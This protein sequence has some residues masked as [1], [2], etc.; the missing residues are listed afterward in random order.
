[1]KWQ[2]ATDAAITHIWPTGTSEMWITCRFMSATIVLFNTVI[3]LF[4]ESTQSGRDG[5]QR[6]IMNK[7]TSETA[8]EEIKD[9]LR[10]LAIADKESVAAYDKALLALSGGGIALSLTF[11]SD[12]VGEPFFLTGL[13]LLRLT[14]TCWVVSIFATVASFYLSHL[15]LRS[16]YKRIANEGLA[17]QP[18]KLWT[19][20]VQSAN[21]LSGFAF[22]TGL[23]AMLMF[24]HGNLE[25]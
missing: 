21:I 1:M 19:G 2:I 17:A 18:R 22:I 7:T 5:T 14:W 13:G 4:V 23:V 10:Q 3:R 20:L 8:D 12:I 25:A 6:I 16:T 9:H 11:I 15:A 24:A